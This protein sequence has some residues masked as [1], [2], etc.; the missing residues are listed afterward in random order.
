MR[1]CAGRIVGIQVRSYR[2][3]AKAKYTWLSSTSKGGPSPGV[4]LHVPLPVDGNGWPESTPS[5]TGTEG[6]LK[7]DL[8]VARRKSLCVAIAGVNNFKRFADAIDWFRP[9][10]FVLALDSDVCVNQ[11]VAASFVQST[12]L[13]RKRGVEP[14]AEVWDAESA[15]GI[16]DLIALDGKSQILSG[17]LFT[18]LSLIHI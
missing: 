18:D 6:P 4:P 1:D 10:R 3:D 16:D 14:A 8:F 12:A 13:V 17:D 7:A 5:I 2:K 9:K 15:K 11:A